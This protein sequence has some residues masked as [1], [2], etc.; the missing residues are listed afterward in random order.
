MDQDIIPFE[1]QKEITPEDQDAY[2]DAIIEAAHYAQKPGWGNDG[3]IKGMIEIVRSQRLWVDPNFPVVFSNEDLLQAKRALI[4]GGQQTP[5][6]VV[7]IENPDAKAR[8]HDGKTDKNLLIVDIDGALIFQSAAGTSIDE[9]QVIVEQYDGSYYELML[10][11]MNEE[12]PA[13]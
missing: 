11:M 8:S 1:K 6:R 9:F 4:S 12:G 7:V 5:F 13:V 3:T 2:I 10:R